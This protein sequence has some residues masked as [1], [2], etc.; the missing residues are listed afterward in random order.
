MSYL[1]LSFSVVMFLLVDNSL[2][3]IISKLLFSKSKLIKSFS[4]NNEKI[5][6]SFCKEDKNKSSVALVIATNNSFFPSSIISSL[7]FNGKIFLLG[8]YSSFKP[9]IKTTLLSIPFAE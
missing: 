5:G 2:P 4:S 7:L 1:L 8:K 3:K 9:K 6:L